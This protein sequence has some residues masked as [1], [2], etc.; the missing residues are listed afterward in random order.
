MRNGERNP[1][2][3]QAQ[4]NR[5]SIRRLSLGINVKQP[6]D[7]R[8]AGRYLNG[9]LKE[10]DHEHGPFDIEIGL[11]VN[12]NPPQASPPDEPKYEIVF[13]PDDGGDYEEEGVD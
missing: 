4:F 11:S 7:L 9:F 12:G 1:T 6:K 13:I 5:Q 2:Q 3:G 8:S 10:I